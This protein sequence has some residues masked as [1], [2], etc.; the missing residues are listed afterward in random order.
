MAWIARHFAVLWETFST[1]RV[2]ECVIAPCTIVLGLQGQEQYSLRCFG[3]AGLR[4]SAAVMQLLRESPQQRE[5]RSLQARTSFP[6][7]CRKGLHMFFCG[8]YC[9]RRAL[10]AHLKCIL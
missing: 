3:P 2:T 9:A 8:A 7:M 5:W 1:Q 6:D 4:H 10:S